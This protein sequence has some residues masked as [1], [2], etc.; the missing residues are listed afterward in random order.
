MH[1]KVPKGMHQKEGDKNACNI[2]E[3]NEV[4]KRQKADYDMMNCN[5]KGLTCMFLHPSDYMIL[6]VLI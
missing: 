2:S 1:M 4:K 6:C 5:V 3:T